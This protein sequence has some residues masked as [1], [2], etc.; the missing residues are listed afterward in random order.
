MLE[1]CVANLSAIDFKI[2]RLYN[3]QKSLRIVTEWYDID[4]EQNSSI[5]NA[6]GKICRLCTSFLDVGNLLYFESLKTDPY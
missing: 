3:F 6:G 2:K 1:L 5:I 4:T